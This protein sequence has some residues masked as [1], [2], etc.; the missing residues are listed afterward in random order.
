MRLS[1]VSYSGKPIVKVACGGE[2]SV[3]VDSFGGLHTFGSPEYGQLG[4]L[5]G[6]CAVCV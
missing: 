2:F 3:I 6:W 5:L 4:K 1:Q